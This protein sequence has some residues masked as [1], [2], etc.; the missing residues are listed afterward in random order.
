MIEIV[1]ET[2][3]FVWMLIVG[4]ISLAGWIG[5]RNDNLSSWFIPK[6]VGTFVFIISLSVYIIFLIS[7]NVVFV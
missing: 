7:D 3:V 4:C 1:T 5:C 2:F 6:F